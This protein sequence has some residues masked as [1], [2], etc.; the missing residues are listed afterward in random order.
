M[1]DADN[2][3]QRWDPEL[4]VQYLYNPV[5]QERKELETGGGDESSVSTDGTNQPMWTGEHPRISFH[6]F[7]PYS[8]LSLLFAHTLP[9]LP[10]YLDF[11][12][13]QRKWT[14]IADTPTTR[15]G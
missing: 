1:S 6:M 11:R 15:T 3:E 7:L 13:P 14:R 9:N 12:L 10:R 8:T 4:N 5:T 2:W